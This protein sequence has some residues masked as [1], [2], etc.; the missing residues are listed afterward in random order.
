[1][2]IDVSAELEGKYLGNQRN[3]AELY[4]FWNNYTA[5][6]LTSSDQEITFGG[7]TFTPTRLSRGTTQHSADLSVSTLSIDIYYI[8]EEITQYLTYAPIDQS[9]IKVEKVFLNQDPMESILYFIGLFDS[10]SF[11]GQNCRVMASGIEKIL[12]S[13]YPK[14]RYQPRCNHKLFSDLCGV[15]KA[16][17]I[18]IDTI[19]NIS[20]DGLQITVT[21]LSAYDDQHFTFGYINPSNAGPRLIVNHVG[22]IL[23]VRS[24]IPN[25]EIGDSISFYPGCDKRPSTCKDKFNNLG[26]SSLDSFLGFIYIPDDNPAVWT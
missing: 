26:N 24:L 22:N 11:Q 18:K 9:W 17:Y 16:S 6:Y 7:H 10:V 12:R 14:I 21:N 20:S 1:M 13:P 8:H 15:N 19:T 25:I 4:T 23:T 5:Y 2:P 3:P